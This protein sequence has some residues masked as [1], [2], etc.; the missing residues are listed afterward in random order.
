MKPFVTT[1]EHF[2]VIYCLDQNVEFT[3]N[4]FFNLPSTGR[5]LF[6]FYSCNLLGT[7]KRIK[8]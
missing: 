6:S 3:E 7:I 8:N 5:T 2:H 4:A 1:G